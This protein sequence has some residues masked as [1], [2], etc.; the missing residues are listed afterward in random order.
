MGVQRYWRAAVLAVPVGAAAGLVPG[1]LF[2]FLSSPRAT[3]GPAS[4]IWYWLAIGSAFGAATAASALIG[5]ACAV[6]V[7][8]PAEPRALRRCA[9]AGAAIGVAVAGS[10]A[11]V[12]AGIWTGLP[13]IA[14]GILFFGLVLSLVAAVVARVMVQLEEVGRRGVERV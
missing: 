8:S 6:L 14:V 7:R 4:T 13:V 11:A 12:W 9:S 2:F 1:A 5:A 10:A 3:A